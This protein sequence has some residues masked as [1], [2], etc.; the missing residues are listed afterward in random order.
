ML[1]QRLLGS[2]TVTSH[3]K[4]YPQP[5]SYILPQL[6][7]RTAFG[8]PCPIPARQT[9]Q[10]LRQVIHNEYAALCRVDCPM[11]NQRQQREE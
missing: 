6:R 8:K 3:L 4:S 5:C 1:N 11:L 7:L 9:N 2:M 10:A